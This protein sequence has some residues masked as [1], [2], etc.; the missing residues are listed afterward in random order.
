MGI[1][2]FPV[3]LRAK[4]KTRG[5]P[6][7]LEMTASA[8]MSWQLK[9]NESEITKAMTDVLLYGHGAMKVTTKGIKRVKLK[10][11]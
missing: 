1:K 10:R 4:G 2:D 3:R 7:K 5:R 6:S 11:G 9:K 8:I